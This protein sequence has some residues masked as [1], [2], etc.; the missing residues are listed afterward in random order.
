MDYGSYA[1]T[2]ATARWAV[3]W[4]LE[5]LI[6]HARRTPARARVLEI[7][8]GTGNYVE[9]LRAAVLHRTFIGVDRSIDMILQ[10]KQRRGGVAYALADADGPLPLASGTMALIFV[11]DVLHHLTRYSTFFCEVARVLDSGGTF[12]AVTDS[13]EN[14]RR[15]SLT[16]FFPETLEI[17]NRRHPSLEELDAAAEHGDLCRVWTALAEGHVALDDAFLAKLEAKCSSAMRLISDA[18][19][20]RGMQRV[21]AASNAGQRWL[22]SYTVLAYAARGDANR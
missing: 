20:Q 19:H 14:I 13:S 18:D 16:R 9:A 22:S 17:E 1:S 4:I 10:A 2:Y 21:R 8:C 11:V 5:P 15:R 3:P 6:E 7:G 12:V